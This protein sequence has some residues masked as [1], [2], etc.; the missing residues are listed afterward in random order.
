MNP[1]I[2]A[3]AA[4]T[5]AP[6]GAAGLPTPPPFAHD[7]AQ[8]RAALK[9]IEQDG[10]GL[11]GPDAGPD[12]LAPIVARLKGARVIGIGEATHG[13]HE[14]Q[15]F[16]TN[17][18]RALI[19]DGAI[20]AVAMEAGRSAVAGL[21]H[22]VRTGEGDP[23]ALLRANGFYTIW[24]NEELAGFL[25]WLRAWNLTAAK[26]VRIFGID[27]Q[28]AG[29]DAALALAL[30]ARHD[31]ALAATLGAPLDPLLPKPGKDLLLPYLWI[32]ADDGAATAR[33]MA[34]TRAIA[35]T[36]EAHRP[37]WGSDPD[38]A[39]ARYAAEIAWQNFNEDELETNHAAYDGKRPDGYSSRRDVF[40]AANLVALTNGG[41]RIGLWAHNG[42][43]QHAVAPNMKDTT[44]L[45]LELRKRLGDDYR[46]LGFVWSRGSIITIVDT[47]ANIG[48]KT[49][50][51][52]SVLALL[53]DRPSEIGSIFARTKSN[54]LWIDPTRRPHTPLL[55]AWVKV[56]YWDG[57]AGALVDPAQWQVDKRVAGDQPDFDQMFDVLVWFRT[58][59][60]TRRLP[61]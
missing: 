4:A 50:A 59:S 32:H 18:L 33:A 31:P 49:Q 60:P 3:L 1:L 17:M 42:H 36:I 45:G 43:L 6:N 53:N 40:M 29:R 48:K 28:D 35:D 20:S 37:Q 15:Q 12:E 10:H 23:A 25:V 13:D 7:A 21:D 47:I 46:C 16:K 41:E 44:T 22:Y 19:R 27:N 57:A 51:Q 8:E 26:P 58:I 5:A 34:A 14:D 54:A 52:A 38:Y 56:P 30:I 24:R 2:F 39:E 61:A 55:D 9:W 11:S